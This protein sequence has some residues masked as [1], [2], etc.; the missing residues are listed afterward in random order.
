MG[1]KMEMIADMAEIALIR[2][3]ERKPFP[4]GLLVKNETDPGTH[5]YS[6]EAQDEF[7]E[8]Y[9]AMESAFEEHNQ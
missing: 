9:D 1:R 5:H 6:E 7:N 2:M 4:N 8:I 3:H